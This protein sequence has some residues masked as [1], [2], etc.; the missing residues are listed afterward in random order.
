M[1]SK[2]TSNSA[3]SF[4]EY[5]DPIT[6]EVMTVLMDRPGGRRAIIA[7]IHKEY[8]SNAKRPTYR[9]Y[10]T[11]GKEVIAPNYSLTQLKK[12]I[13]RNEQMF[14]EQ[15]SL[16][17]QALQQDFVQEERRRHR[18]LRG[19]RSTKGKTQSRTR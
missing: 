13:R 8:D 15:V 3:I 16:K 19:L 5:K 18:E 12:E 10:D 14:H 17:E 6:D 2:E 9:T 11:D 4:A 7:H 1:T